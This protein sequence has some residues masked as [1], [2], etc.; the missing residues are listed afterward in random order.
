M[1]PLK[2]QLNKEKIKY[3]S[4]EIIRVFPKF[5]QKKFERLVFDKL[6]TLELK[7]RVSLI[8]YA[9]YEIL[10]QS[11]EESISILLKT[12]C[13]EKDFENHQWSGSDYD[14]VSGFLVWPLTQFVQDYGINHFETSMDAL[15]E[16]TKRFTG[17]FAIRT[18]IAH[19]DEKVFDLLFSKLNHPSVH[20]RRLISEGTRPNLPWAMKV[21]KIHNNLQRNIKLISHLKDDPEEYVRKSVANHLNDISKIDKDL[22]LKTCKKWFDKENAERLKLI[23]H[24]CRTLLKKGDIEALKLNKYIT[25]PKIEVLVFKLSNKKVKKGES[26]KLDVKLSSRARKSQKLL[27]DYIIYFPSKRGDIRKKVFRLKD[28]KLEGFTELSIKKTIS[29]K[30]LTIRSYYE[31]LYKVQLK[32]GSQLFDTINFELI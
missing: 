4:S 26:I 21:E 27:I 6:L 29:F 30:D 10:P 15:F 14:G 8:S 17:E 5:N 28:I 23:K 24:A 2:D 25:N 1:T 16:M 12:L 31:G 11:Y 9:L 22:M 13:L 7:E 20:V 19:Y 3:L 18:F 32:V